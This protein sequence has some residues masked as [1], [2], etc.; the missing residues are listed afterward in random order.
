M[1]SR[2]V[3]SW[4]SAVLLVLSIPAFA[5]EQTPIENEVDAPYRLH[6][7]VWVTGQRKSLKGTIISGRDPGPHKLEI[8][9]VNDIVTEVDRERVRE[10]QSRETPQSA[11]RSRSK[12]VESTKNPDL[13]RR[14]AEWGLTQ[15]LGLE[16][17]KQLELAAK[18]AKGAS[19]VTHRERV[20]DLYEARLG[21]LDPEAPE[22]AKIQERILAHAKATGGEA[23]PR[24]L[25]GRA[26]VQ[27][28]LGLAESALPLLAKA[29]TL[30]DAFSQDASRNTEPKDGEDGEDEGGEDEGGEDEGG[31]DE[32]SEDEGGEDEGGEDKGD[33]D[34]GEPKTPRKRPGRGFG[35][36]DED[37]EPNQRRAPPKAPPAPAKEPT[38]NS[39]TLLPG[40]IKAERILY[41]ELLA[42]Q[43]YAALRAGT[44]EVAKQAY[45]RRLEVWP[46]DV[47]ASLGQARLFSRADQ[48]A[49]AIA[50]L[51]KALAVYPKSDELLLLRGQLRYLESAFGE[52]QSDLERALVAA[53]EDAFARRP[54]EVAL[55]LLHLAGARFPEAK[56]LLEAA[57]ADPGYGPARLG[58][59]LLSELQGDLPAANTQAAEAQRMLGKARGEAHYVR[60]WALRK[61]G[62]LAEASAALVEGIRDGYD[63]ELASRARIDIARQASDGKQEARL[64]ELLVRSATTPTPD[65]LAALGRVYLRQERAVEAQRLFSRGLKITPT[66]AG[67]LRGLAF[68]AYQRDERLKSYALFKQ[69][70]EQDKDDAWAARGLKHLEQARSRRVWT[71]DFDRPDG[72]VLNAWTV[73][74]PF[75]VQPRIVDKALSFSGAQKNDPQ[76]KTQLFR[77]VSGETVV[78]LAAKLR[79]ADTN[80]G[81]AGIRMESKSYQAILF[82]NP[83]DGG[84]Y[85]STRRGNQ[86][87]STPK[88]LGRWPGPGPHTLAIDV[89]DP[90]RGRLAFLVDGDRRGTAEVG[91][92]SR[93]H[94]V[95]LSLYAQGS[96]EGDRV[97]FSV[98]QAWIYVLRPPKK[99]KPGGF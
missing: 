47:A 82:R 86:P 97:E 80:Q 60:A 55:G 32:G 72:D 74:A 35:R 58:R 40:L 25:V 37:L 94:A 10:I 22:I 9:L 5:Q 69:L 68:C 29:K 43:A 75:G 44:P 45:A 54:V 51:T 66:H 46:E 56:K 81:R 27:L 11:F 89:E 49:A 20:V 73:E 57:D 7:V 3:T 67:C 65:Q 52:A 18:R 28:Q 16:A 14:L 12:R 95:T 6:D 19:A 17:E 99:A 79:I 21:E 77:A 71:D 98:E 91:N 64:T 62:K 2:D 78:K 85:S 90:K 88:N 61:S 50:Q 4:V 83:Q 84:V 39:G 1:R 76:G 30:L 26:R 63:F 96:Q 59:A 8:R 31:E 15:G 92:T 34:K 41:R 13:H 87:W 23:S 93:R 33:E 38:D 48:R 53:G 42:D 70:L 24:L 36:G